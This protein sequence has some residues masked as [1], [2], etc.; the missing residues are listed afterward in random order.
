MVLTYGDILCKI[1]S[2]LNTIIIAYF[3]N[4]FL[5][6]PIFKIGKLRILVLVIYNI[7]Y[8]S[9]NRYRFPCAGPDLVGG[10]RCKHPGRQN[11]RL[12]GGYIGEKTYILKNN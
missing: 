2:K 4:P 10:K 1:K 8:S 6:Y 12:E 9:F 5:K 3:K 11:A 7:F